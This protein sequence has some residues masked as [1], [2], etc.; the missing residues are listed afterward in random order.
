MYAKHWFVSI[1]MPYL[2]HGMQ[3]SYRGD[4]FDVTAILFDEKS[5]SL[6]FECTHNNVY[7]LD[8]K[9]IIMCTIQFGTAA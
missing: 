1:Q 4:A 8:N 5:I 7:D 2:T 9:H 6:V 3:K